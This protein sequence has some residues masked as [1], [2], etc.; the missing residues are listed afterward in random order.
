[1]RGMISKKKIRASDFASDIR[2]GLRDSRLMEKYGLSSKGLQSAFRKL[3]EA[4][5]MDESELRERSRA[6]EDTVDINEIRLLD[7]SYVAFQ[8]TIRDADHPEI[9]G[10]L[11]DVTEQGLQVVGIE[12]AANEKRR[13]MVPAEEFSNVA[14]FSFEA[15]CRWSRIQ[16]EDGARVG[17]FQITEIEDSGK[18]ELLKLI[19]YAG[20]SE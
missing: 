19:S 17:G 8:V 20:F 15:V 4:G 18:K 14:P 12:T 16:N 6:I 10:Y 13:F 2:S 1:G 3:V 5:I 11:V 9:E 7:R